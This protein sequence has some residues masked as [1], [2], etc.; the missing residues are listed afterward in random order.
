MQCKGREGRE[1][2]RGTYCT[3]ISFRTLFG[4]GGL[5]GPRIPRLGT[6]WVTGLL[7]RSFCIPRWLVGFM[8]MGWLCV[9]VGVD[10]LPFLGVGH[11]W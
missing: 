10:G 1:R 8:Y 9:G 7:F 2:S 11:R 3:Q 4:M 5:S 6:V